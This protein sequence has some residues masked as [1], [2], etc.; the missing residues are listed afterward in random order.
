MLSKERLAHSEMNGFT[1]T[2]SLQASYVASWGKAHGRD[3]RCHATVPFSFTKLTVYIPLDAPGRK[4]QGFV[5]LLQDSL[6]LLLLG[7][8]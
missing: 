3:P 4:F 6:Q 5:D 2:W 8:L 7:N 1:A